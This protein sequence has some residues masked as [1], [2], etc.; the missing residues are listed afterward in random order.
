VTSEDDE[1][2]ADLRNFSLDVT[3][4][5]NAKQHFRWF[6]CTNGLVLVAVLLLLLLLLLLLPF[7][8]AIITT[9]SLSLFLLESREGA[10]L[11]F[12]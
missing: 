10:L 6:H 5:D 4:E 2:S 12:F 9:L 3:G 7:F 8:S 11:L 1:V